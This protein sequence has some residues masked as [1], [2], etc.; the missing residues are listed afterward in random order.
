MDSIPAE[1]SRDIYGMPAFV[2]L[3]VSDLDRTVDWYVN[4][5]DFIS[6]F[7]VPGPGGEPAL[8]HLRRWRYQDILVRPGKADTGQGWTIGMM[9]TLEQLDALAERARAHGGGT[10]DG[11]ADTP[12]NTRD[13]RVTDPDGYTVVYTARR[14]EGDR[15]ARFNAMMEEEGRRQLGTPE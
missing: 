8:V 10:V 2:S 7:T 1:I 9:A 3:T 12:W 11:P 15:D 14:A 4:G 13:L 6:L 5:L